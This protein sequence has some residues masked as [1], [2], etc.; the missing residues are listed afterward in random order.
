MVIVNRI[1]C[2]RVGAILQTDVENVTLRS[3]EL[4]TFTNN[5][6][7]QLNTTF[8]CEVSC[9]DTTGSIEEELRNNSRDRR[10]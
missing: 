1:A 4:Q 7:P 10:Y 6:Q 5:L 3:G 9:T 2:S 8:T